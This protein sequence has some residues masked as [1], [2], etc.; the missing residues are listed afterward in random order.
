MSLYSHGMI[1]NAAAV[2]RGTGAYDRELM[3]QRLTLE[4]AGRHKDCLHKGIL[5]KRGT[6]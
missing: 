4:V 5:L 3:D 6:P 2:A 1:S